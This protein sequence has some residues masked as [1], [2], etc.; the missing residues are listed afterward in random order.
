MSSP[1]DGARPRPQLMN[2]QMRNR[3][4]ESRLTPNAISLTGLV[5][6]LA[7]AAL[8]WQEMWILGGIAFWLFERRDVQGA[9]GGG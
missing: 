5:L 2:D 3:L 6:C 4:I 9:T 1:G 7:A 8:V